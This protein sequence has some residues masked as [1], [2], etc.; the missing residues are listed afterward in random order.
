M[1]TASH[2]LS[3]NTAGSLVPGHERRADVS[4]RLAV[5]LVVGVHVASDEDGARGALDSGPRRQPGGA[6]PGLEHRVRAIE[7]DAGVVEEPVRPRADHGVGT[8]VEAVER[9]CRV[10]FLR[11]A[12]QER[13]PP[14]GSAVDRREDAQPRVAGHLVFRVGRGDPPSGS[15]SLRP[16]GASGCA[17]KRRPSARSAAAGTGRLQASP[18]P[19]PCSRC[20]WPPVLPQRRNRGGRGEAT[21]GRRQ[22]CPRR[23]DTQG[24]CMVASRCRSPSGVRSPERMVGAGRHARRERICGTSLPVAGR[25]ER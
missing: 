24:R 9:R 4:D 10:R 5:L 15:R 8:G 14:R 1:S 12:G 6:A 13:A 18:C 23:V 3:R 20:G 25:C 19:R 7:D 2:G 22:C 21:R 11:V 17:S 16:A